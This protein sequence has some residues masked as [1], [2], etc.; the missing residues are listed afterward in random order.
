[1][2]VEPCPI[3]PVEP[4]E[5]L[6]PRRPQR[7]SVFVV[8]AVQALQE[9]D[10]GQAYTESVIRDGLWQLM[11]GPIRDAQRPPQSS[12]KRTRQILRRGTETLPA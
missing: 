7:L 4:I 11:L 8:C 9:T 12:Y 10:G 6:Q 2:A 5:P 3:Q 1:M